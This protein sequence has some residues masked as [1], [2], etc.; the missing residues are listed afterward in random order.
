LKG[1]AEYKRGLAPVAVRRA[2]QTA[3]SIG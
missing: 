2:L 3:L 1:S